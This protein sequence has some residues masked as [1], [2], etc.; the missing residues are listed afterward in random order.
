ML[1]PCR[2]PPDFVPAKNVDNVDLFCNPDDSAGLGTVA[3]SADCIS[4]ED[5]PTALPQIP[6]LNAPAPNSTATPEDTAMT[7]LWL[8]ELTRAEEFRALQY[9]DQPAANDRQDESTSW[10]QR[11]P[12]A[13]YAPPYYDPRWVGEATNR[14]SG[15]ESTFPMP[16]PP[17]AMMASQYY[18][19]M[20]GSETRGTVSSSFPQQQYGNFGGYA[21]GNVGFVPLSPYAP[22]SSSLEHGFIARPDHTLH[23][24]YDNASRGY[25][26][27]HR[28]ADNDDR[29]HD[30][31]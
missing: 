1:P 8:Y 31:R 10:P 4:A 21:Y 19:Y 25:G 22:S 28:N 30:R 18:G 23:F 7:A 27:A 3:Q 26:Y 11:N 29:R 12:S 2:Y 5:T 16:T 6:G 13:T 24:P 15:I 17:Q 20:D 14:Y 9:A